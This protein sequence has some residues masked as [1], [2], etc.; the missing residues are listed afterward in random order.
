MAFSSHIWGLNPHVDEVWSL[1]VGM[2]PDKINEHE[3]L[4]YRFY[5][6]DSGSDNQSE[7]FV[8][9][10]YITSIQEWAK[11]TERWSEELN[12]GIPVKAFKM[13]QAAA[14]RR[15]FSG[16]KGW[17]RDKVDKKIIS[18]SEIIKDHCMAG[19]SV[20]MRH[21]DF[22]STIAQL[23][24]LKKRTLLDD[25]PYHSMLGIFILQFWENCL[26]LSVM[27]KC[28]FV[29]DDQIGFEEQ[30]VGIWKTCR[31]FMRDEG[32]KKKDLPFIGSIPIFRSDDAFLPL[33]AADLLGWIT[34]RSEMGM[35]LNKIP[36]EAMKNLESV[37]HQIFRVKKDSMSGH[38]DKWIRK[39]RELSFLDPSTKFYYKR[40]KSKG[41]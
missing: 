35:C 19:F 14:L 28:D 22:E 12:E 9:S 6:D 16:Q 10:G 15:E 32:F 18:L 30:A 11:L 34:R 38:Y 20:C 37:P 1:V 33:Q 3:V 29:L 21:E 25:N 27:D 23:G 7:M 36:K 31:A 41:L 2:T 8:L 17:T 13:C 5:I 40:V 39:E 24:T 26:K 4:I